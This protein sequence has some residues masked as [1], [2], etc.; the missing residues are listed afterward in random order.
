MIGVIIQ[1]RMGSTRL[2]GKVLEKVDG[3]PLLKYQYDRVL[4]SKRVDKIIIA[5]SSEKQDDEIE[6]FCLSL[7]ISCYRGSEK[8]VL[9]RYYECALE[10]HIKT[11][12]RLTGDCPLIDPVVI[13]ETIEIF[14]EESSDYACNTAPPETSCFPDGSDVEVFSFEALSKAH[15]ECKKP[16]DR[17]HVTF[18]LWKQDNGFKTSQLTMKDNFSKYRFTLDYPED[19][20]VLDFLIKTLRKKGMFGHVKEVVSLLDSNPDIKKL[21]S[22]YYFGIGWEEQEEKI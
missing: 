15:L 2:P 8:D 11:V 19:L 4:K 9:G 6:K 18:Y 17:E 20:K 5:T 10:N 16:H 1:A 13:D 14:Q 3:I 22:Q 7:G 21:N 12:V